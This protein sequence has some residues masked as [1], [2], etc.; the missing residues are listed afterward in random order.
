MTSLAKGGVVFVV[1]LVLGS[2]ALVGCVP[3]GAAGCSGTR[4]PLRVLAEARGKTIGTAFRPQYAVFDPCYASAAAHDFNSLT[5][6]I[7]TFPNAIATAPGV[8]NFAD[9][10]SVCAFAKARRMTCQVHDLVWD[11]LTHP[12]W[13][14]VP[15]WIRSEPPSARRATMIDLV[16]QVATHFRGRVDYYNLV[17]EAFDDNGGLAPTIWNTSGDDSY[18]FDAFRAARRADPYA[19]MLYNDYGDEGINAKSNAIFSLAVRLHAETEA[20]QVYGHTVQRPL[21]DGV[22]LQMHVGTGPS[23]APTPAAVAQNLARLRKAGLSARFTEMDVRT[24][25]VNGVVSSSNLARQRALY[26]DLVGTCVAASNC[27]SI[28]VWGFTDAHSW[29]ND[30]P[31]SFNGEAAADLFT[32]QYQPKPAYHGVQTALVTP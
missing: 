14:I 6:E 16:T 1:A 3:V 23:E 30:Y 15:Q 21:L 31:A 10:D 19:E 7:A 11:P 4:F 29:I 17:N 20:V 22:G 24:P 5:P 32:R 28:T 13:G 9:A 26:T 8:Y 2:A 27:H 12:E 25:T 18:I